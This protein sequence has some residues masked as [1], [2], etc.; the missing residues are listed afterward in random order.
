MSFFKRKPLSRRAVLR[1]LLG[2]TAISLALP[3]L[4]AMFNATG[5]AYACD[6]ILPVRFGVFFWGNGNVPDFWT[7]DA[8]GADYELSS[9]LAPLAAVKERFSVLTG[10]SVQ[11]QNLYP[12][13]SGMAGVMT[14]WSLDNDEAVQAPSIDQLIA[15]EIGGETLYR[16]LQTSPSNASGVSWNGPNSQNPPEGDPYALYERLFGE[17][18]REPGEEV[19]VDPALGLR[20]S[21]LDGVLDDLSALE[22]QVGAEDKARLDQHMTGVRE[23][24][25][26]LA[27]LEEDPPNLEACE[28]AIEPTGSFDDIEGR[29][30]ISAKNRVMA[31]MLTMALA[32]DQTRVFGHYF[33]DPVSDALYPEASAG[34]HD[35]THNESGDQPEVQAITTLIM[36]ELAYFIAA[37]DAVPEG[38]GTLLDN[39]TMMATSEV[40]LGQTHSID[41]IPLILAGGACDTLQ[42]GVHLRSVGGANFSKLGLSLIRAMGIPA[43]SWGGEEGLAEDGLSGIEL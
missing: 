25:Q 7:P 9:T 38:D 39:M 36:D 30:R 33:S 1:G 34:H 42:M 27:R 31:D 43:T 6:G 11:H 15:A 14:G 21:I 23:L 32:C 22:S 10:L 29:P 40:S 35:L 16:S 3:P 19:E 18:F 12:H 13:G 41:E 26:R 2:G 37:L 28:R 4:E 20:R 8:E 5:T 24:E 17:T